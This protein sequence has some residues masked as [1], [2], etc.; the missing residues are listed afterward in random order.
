MDSGDIGP[1]LRF[2]A[3]DSGQ[4]EWRGDQA[5]VQEAVACSGAQSRASKESSGGSICPGVVGGRHVLS[6]SVCLKHARR[7]SADVSCNGRGR[8]DQVL[9]GGVVCGLVC[10]CSGVNGR[11]SLVQYYLRKGWAGCQLEVVLH[12]VLWGIAGTTGAVQQQDYY[13]NIWEYGDMYVSTDGGSSSR[14]V[15]QRWMS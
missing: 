7:G 9:W 6:R 15:Q 14:G 4:S 2:M 1:L 11:L 13:G 12:S 5:R 8:L 3:G 10:S